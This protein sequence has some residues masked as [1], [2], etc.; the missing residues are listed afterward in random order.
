MS[1]RGRWQVV[2]TP[3]YDMALASAYI[4]F[5]EAGGEFAFDCLTG[6]IHGACRGDAVEFGWQGNDEMEPANGD[7]WA[8][9]QDDG[10]LEGEK[11]ASST[12]TASHSS[13]AVQ[14]LLQQP[15]RGG[16]SSRS[17]RLALHELSSTVGV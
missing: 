2:E 4:L 17:S 12:A 16:H 9:L 11:S 15:A 8:E 14:R 13:R 3:D 1:I 10:S 7:G 6:S 5:D